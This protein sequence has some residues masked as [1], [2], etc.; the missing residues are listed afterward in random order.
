[1]KID[2]IALLTQTVEHLKANSKGHIEV[3]IAQFVGTMLLTF[4]WMCAGGVLVVAGGLGGAVLDVALGGEG[5]GTLLGL[6]SYPLMFL[7][8][9]LTLPI[10]VVLYFGYQSA[11]LDEVDGKGP[12]SIR[13][14]FG[15]ISA[16]AGALILLTALSCGM[17]M[18]GVLFCYVGM[19]VTA[20]PFKFAHLIRHERGVSL[21]AALGLAWRGFTAA[22]L[23]HFVVM[24]VEFVVTMVLAYIPLIGGMILWP[25]VS[26][27]DVLAYRVLHPKDEGAHAPT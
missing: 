5:I 1:M 18:V 20:L 6:L 24:I 2:A 26:V 19:F 10:L 21:G 4:V 22:P 13:G 25:V 14:V 12:V 23:D 11:T 7:L 9:A 27:F 8:L 3:A 15:I 16:S 17:S